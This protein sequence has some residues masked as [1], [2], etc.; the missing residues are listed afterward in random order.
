MRA[1]RALALA[2]PAAHPLGLNAAHHG[3]TSA[4]SAAAASTVAYFNS[5]R[6]K[7]T[8]GFSFLSPH[9]YTHQGDEVRTDKNNSSAP[10]STP[11]PQPT[12]GLFSLNTPSVRADSDNLLSASEIKELPPTA[13]ALDDPATT[14]TPEA[15]QSIQSQLMR[16]TSKEQWMGVGRDAIYIQMRSHQQTRAPAAGLMSEL[17]K[18]GAP[19]ELCERA[20]AKP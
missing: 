14:Q 18:M 20:N 4:T 17:R 19:L 5:A 15:I 16:F 8:V 3:I 1:L 7:S 13:A 11:P 9:Q 10:P 12:T 2:R 6:Q